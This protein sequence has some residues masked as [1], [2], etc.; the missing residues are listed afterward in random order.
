MSTNDAE[1]AKPAE[2]KGLAAI[3][4]A[5]TVLATIFAGMSS[6]EMT[7]SMYYRSLAAQHQAKTGSQWGFFQAKKM[8]GTT[9]ETAGDLGLM[10][11]VKPF[12]E[13]IAL[14]LLEAIRSVE[15][16]IAAT[17]VAP[18]PAAAKK[19]REQLEA[20][21]LKAALPYLGGG[22]LPAVQARS[23]ETEQLAAMLS[24]IRSRTPESKTVDIVAKLSPEQVDAAIEAAEANAD[25]FDRACE[26]VT[27]A[28][29]KLERSI[30]DVDRL[31]SGVPDP[32]NELKTLAGAV[33]GA[34]QSLRFAAQDFTAR[35]YDREA[36]FNQQIGELYEVQ[37]RLAGHE[38]ERHR[39]RS[40]NFFY[41]MLCAQAGV[42]IASLALAR[43]RQSAFWFIAGLAGLV[44]VAIGAYVYLAM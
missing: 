10:F 20:D 11:N 18:L 16:Q 44:A 23:T 43:S 5:L 4:V 34:A 28:I 33:H 19:L 22:E 7:R 24:A 14:G 13:G 25:A 6:S 42:T 26:P 8:R 2:T 37:V 1:P 40:R 35:R 17:K 39:I 27:T 36:K 31:V 3:P 41:A 15:P 38:S 32:S 21:D 29:R 12:D 9:L 30:V